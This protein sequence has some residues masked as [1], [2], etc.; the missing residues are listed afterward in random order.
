MEVANLS[1]KIDAQTELQKLINKMRKNGE[2]DRHHILFCHESWRGCRLRGNYRL[3]VYM[4][5]DDHHL[6]LHK[7]IPPVPRMDDFVLLKVEEILKDDAK[8]LKIDS[9]IVKRRGIVGV[10]GLDL[11]QR[12]VCL[13]AEM[14]DYYDYQDTLTQISVNL[15]S[16]REYILRSTEILMQ[17]VTAITKQKQLLVNQ[18]INL[19]IS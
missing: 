1:N 11:L 15:L 17:E 16:Q 9:S 10:E 12:A 3:I 18:S 6:G 14:A 2:V 13:V 5:K 4:L 19:A 8:Q 7:H